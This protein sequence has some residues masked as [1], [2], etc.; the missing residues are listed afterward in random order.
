MVSQRWINYYNSFTLYFF[1]SYFEFRANAGSQFRIL[2]T[3]CEQAQQTVNNTLQLFLQRQIVGSQIISQELFKSQINESI[4]EW[5]LNTLNSYLRP[6]QL[7]RVTNQGNQLIN[8]FHNFHF[9]FD[10]TSTQLIP[11]PA[12]YSTCSC[13]KSNS[14]RT[15]MGIYTYNWTTLGYIELFRI[16]NFFSGCFPVESLLESTLE[17]FY[18]RQCMNTIQSYMTNTTPYFSPL[19][20]TFNVPNET[21]QSIIDRLMINSWLSNVSFSAYYKMCAPISCTFEYTRQHDIF[22]LIS[23]ILGIFAGLLFGIKILILISLRFI[24]KLVE[25]LSLKGLGNR[26]KSLF[27]CRNEQQI[28]DRFHF[29][30]LISTVF[31]FYLISTVTL[32]T[33]TEQI[34]KPSPVTYQGLLADY[35]NSLQCPC[36]H[37][38]IEYQ[39]FLTIAPRMH[40]ICS[41]V[42]VSDDWIDYIF[43]NNDPLLLNYTD[44]RTTAAGQ[45]QLLASLCQ[46]SQQV[47]DD[48][49]LNLATSNFINSQLLSSDLLDE[50]IRALVNEVRMTIPNSF[51]NSL[52]LIRQTTEANMLMNMFATNWKFQYE[53]I[54]SIFFIFYTA[55]LDYQECSCGVSSKC[56]QSSQG[57]LA[58]CYPLE[59]LLQSSFQCFYNQTCIDPTQTFRAL[60]TSSNISSQYSTIES[61]LNK[62][63]VE[64]YSVNISYENYFSRCQPTSCSY[65]YVGHNNILDVTLTVIGLYGGLTIIARFLVELFLKLCICRNIKVSPWTTEESE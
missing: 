18:D 37:I 44:F 1:T 54:L 52:S 48:A 42:F 33:K 50:R 29:V 39:S 49:L 11:V 6:V 15:P 60:N 55:P 51:L 12:N 7:I 28:T 32:I 25:D 64:D 47:V 23:S 65:S 4:E 3:L 56:V 63:M 59:A 22:Y 26:F 43:N 62:L 58:G 34:M 31:L 19:N 45:F 8:S 36:L 5:K 41:S 53:I 57:M 40:P 27:I 46:L 35:Q 24:E 2:A 17:C 13:A 10:E 30:L 20:A 38:S 16:P 9:R 14:C 21:I 61:I